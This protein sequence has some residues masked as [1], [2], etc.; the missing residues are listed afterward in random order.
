MNDLFSI[1]LYDQLTGVVDVHS[2]T[3]EIGL[4]KW[5]QKNTYLLQDPN[6]CYLYAI[7][8]IVQKHVIRKRYKKLDTKIRGGAYGL[9]VNGELHTSNEDFS[10]DIRYGLNPVIIKSPTFKMQLPKANLLENITLA[11]EMKKSIESLIDFSEEKSDLN[12]TLPN[13]EELKIFSSL[14]NVNTKNSM[15]K[16]F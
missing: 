3:W 9:N 11:D 15:E 8:G 2:P 5:L 13:I 1:M 12:Y 7:V 6:V 10:L 14:T 4:S 16:E